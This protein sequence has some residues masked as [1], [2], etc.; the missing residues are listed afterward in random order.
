MVGEHST[1]LTRCLH[2][3][4]ELGVHG[5]VTGVVPADASSSPTVPLLM[6]ACGVC[7]CGGPASA[8]RPAAVGSGLGTSVWV[9]FFA[10]L[11]LFK[12]LPRVQ[13]G[14]VQSAIFPW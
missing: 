1:S 3:S 13:F 7:A 10:G 12:N 2:G 14:E 6:S 9:T 5:F 8:H 4:C 11:L